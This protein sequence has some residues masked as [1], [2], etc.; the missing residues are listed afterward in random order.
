MDKP[1]AH[2]N[3]QDSLR[4]ELGRSHHLPLYSIIYDWPHG[5]HSNIILFWD[6]QVGSLKILEIKTPCTLE[7]HNFLC[8]PLI[9]MGSKEKL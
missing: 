8:K 1:Q 9:E 7:V 4:F 5:L 6:F 2:I 3:S